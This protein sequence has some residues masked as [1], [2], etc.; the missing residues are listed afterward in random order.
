[1]AVYRERMSA[2]LNPWARLR[3]ILEMIKF[4]HTIF[5]LPFAFISVIL[6]ARSAGLPN[7]LPSAKTVFWVLVA[8]V[9]ARS[10]AMAFNRVADASYDAANPRTSNRAIPAGLLSKFE[11]GLFTAASCALLV[12]SAGMLNRL[13]LYLSPVALGATLG[14]SLTKRF[15]SLCHLFLGFAIGIAPVGAWIAITGRLEAIPLM[16]GAAVMLWIGGFDIIYALQDVEFDRST[17]LHSLPNRLGRD[18]ALLVSRLMHLVMIGL[19]GAIGAMAHLHTAYSLGVVVVA[20]LIGYEQA[21][22]SPKDLSRVNVAFFT[23]NGWVSV[24]LFAFV[25]MDRLVTP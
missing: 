13:C 15:T 20:G 2:N 11:V 12:L 1:M 14:Y 16:L 21:I 10:A 6:A 8:M 9:G 17:G 5:A 23:L 7:G 24:S 19:L 25:L 18:K 4:E 22:V 3:V